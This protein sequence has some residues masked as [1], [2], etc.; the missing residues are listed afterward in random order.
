MN[1]ITKLLEKVNVNSFKEIQ[2]RNYPAYI[3]MD[4]HKDTIVVSIATPGRSRLILLRSWAL[5]LCLIPPNHK[6]WA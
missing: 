2:T 6:P 5:W 3:G 1:H 4:T